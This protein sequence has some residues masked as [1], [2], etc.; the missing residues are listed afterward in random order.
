[1]KLHQKVSKTDSLYVCRDC[2]FVNDNAYDIDK[3]P[4]CSSDDWVEF[5]KVKDI[6]DE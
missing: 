5:K 3:C 2:D 4:Y 1:M 6:D